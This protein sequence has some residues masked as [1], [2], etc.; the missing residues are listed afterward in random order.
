[1]LVAVSKVEG[2]LIGPGILLPVLKL[3]LVFE[4]PAVDGCLLF[5]FQ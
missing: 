5:F 3:V 4:S 2:E 1:M